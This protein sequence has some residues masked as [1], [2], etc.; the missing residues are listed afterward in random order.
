[1][2]LNKQIMHIY[3]LGVLTLSSFN[4]K[5]DIVCAVLQPTAD[6]DELFCG[7]VDRRKTFSFISNW[8]YCQISSPSRISNALRAGFELVQNLSS[9]FAE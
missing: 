2:I 1:M 8:G 4:M 9:G 7:M 5:W 3:E 6:D